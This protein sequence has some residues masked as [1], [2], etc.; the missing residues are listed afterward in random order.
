MHRQKFIQW[1][2]SYSAT[3]PSSILPRDTISNISRLRSELTDSERDLERRDED[4]DW[5]RERE[6]AEGARL[7]E[8]D[9]AESAT[10]GV[11]LTDLTRSTDL[12]LPLPLSISELYDRA[13]EADRSCTMGRTGVILRGRGVGLF[14]A[15]GDGLLFFVNTF[16]TGE[17]LPRGGVATR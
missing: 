13:G 8:R 7:G 12:A 10:L 17:G 3:C 6:R 11:R 2:L 5:E 14:R 15:I 1:T 16:R 4:L 9:L